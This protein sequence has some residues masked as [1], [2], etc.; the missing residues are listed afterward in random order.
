MECPPLLSPYFSLLSLGFCP[1][2]RN[3]IYVVIFWIWVEQLIDSPFS[4]CKHTLFH[5]RDP[6]QLSFFLSDCIFCEFDFQFP[7]FLFFSSLSL[8]HCLLLRP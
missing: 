1:L 5:P 4:L 6:L 2:F 7:D 8:D 3:I